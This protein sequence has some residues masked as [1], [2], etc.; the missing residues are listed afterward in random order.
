MART[1]RPPGMEPS[2]QMSGA[3][4]PKPQW[5]HFQSS[6]SPAPKTT[7]PAHR[8]QPVASFLQVRP[9]PT[10]VTREAAPAAHAT[11]GSS[12]LATTALPAGKS[13]QARRQRW[14]TWRTSLLR[15][16]WSRL[17]LSSTTTDGRT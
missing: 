6:S 11:R 17:R 10:Q 1:A 12:A 8:G 16:S 5:P 15:S 13:W 7:G 9:A 2:S 4:R 3:G 14:A